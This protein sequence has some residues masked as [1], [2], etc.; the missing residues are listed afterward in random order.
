MDIRLRCHRHGN[1][2]R[3]YRDADALIL[4]LRVGMRITDD[5]RGG[6][7][8]LQ[9]EH[10]TQYLPKRDRMKMLTLSV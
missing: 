1:N 7:R 9:V 5:G 3:L 4:I 10:G 6:E 8:R 2:E